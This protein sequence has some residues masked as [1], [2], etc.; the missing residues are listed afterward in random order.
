MQTSSSNIDNPNE[1]FICNIIYETPMDDLYGSE[2]V[3]CSIKSCKLNHLKCLGIYVDTD[4][5]KSLEAFAKKFQFK[6]N[7]HLERTP[8]YFDK[9][10][11]VKGQGG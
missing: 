8:P 6:C 10:K 1:C 9:F 11:A 7:K 4:G 3:E 5:E 2:W